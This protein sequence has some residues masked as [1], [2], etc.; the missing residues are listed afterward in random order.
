MTK[1]RDNRFSDPPP[2]PAPDPADYPKG[3]KPGDPGFLDALA[4]EAGFAVTYKKAE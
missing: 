2:L 1:P 3:L 4:K